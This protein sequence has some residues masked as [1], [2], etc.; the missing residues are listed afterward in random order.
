MLRM[1]QT[2]TRL[3]NFHCLGGRN[4]QGGADPHDRAKAIRPRPAQAAGQ[5][6]DQATG[7]CPQST[8]QVTS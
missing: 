2:C 7:H 6:T 1:V 3:V 8:G 5:D 4:V